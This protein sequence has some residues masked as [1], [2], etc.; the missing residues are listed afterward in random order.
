VC[1]SVLRVGIF[2]ERTMAKKFTLIELLVVVAI[3]GILA[4]ILMPHL[5]ESRVRAIKVVCLNNTSQ[6]NKS[7][8]GN[9][10]NH[11]G[12][13]FWDT[14]TTNNGNW[15]NNITYRNTAE[16][17]LPQE[18][19]FCPVKQGYDTDSA[20]VHDVSYRVANYS[21]TFKR[22][23]GNLSTMTINDQE[24]VDRY[25]S[26]DNPS[27][28]K[29][30]IDDTM[31]QDGIFSHITEYGEKTNHYNRGKMDQSSAYV[32]GSAKLTHYKTWNWRV[33]AGSD[34]VFWW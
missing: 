25:Y 19:Y 27:E 18:L 23:N 1:N 9:A 31:K 21:F 5:S 13:Y 29:L 14:V 6:L 22:P 8:V 11:D 15:P 30:I 12:R 20:W 4:S 7:F 16:L 26:V 32:D 34:R 24:W 17:D 33:D 3:I 2:V 10:E 28:T